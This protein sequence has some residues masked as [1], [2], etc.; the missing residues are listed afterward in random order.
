MNYCTLTCDRGDRPQ[1]FEF[2]IKQLKS[3]NG[4][5]PPTNA[6]LINDKPK[7]DEFDLIPR[8]KQGIELAKR[9]GFENVYCIESD[10][11]YPADYF[12]KLPIGDCDFIGYSDT[13]YYNLR[14]RTYATFRHPGRSSLFT[15]AFK[16][17]ALDGFDWPS[18]NKVF[19]DVALWKFA[20]K[21]KKKITLIK[22]NPCLGIKHGLGLVGGKGHKMKMQNKDNDLR[23]LRSRVSEEAFEFYKTLM[24]TL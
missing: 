19:L 12:Q 21:T 11:Y 17:S 7:T 22:G 1:F 13:T 8:F 4:D 23:F 15:T 16:I 14:N 5:A 24:L 20:Q 10:D 18:D 2:C 9:D 3:L 6:Y